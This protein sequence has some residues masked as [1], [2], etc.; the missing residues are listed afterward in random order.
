MAG[1]VGVQWVLIANGCGLF[2][3]GDENVL[4]FYYYDGC[5]PCEYTKKH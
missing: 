4:N 5:K 1:K 2:F 3:R